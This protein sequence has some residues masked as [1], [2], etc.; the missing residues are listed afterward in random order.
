ML[1]FSVVSVCDFVCLSVRMFVNTV[2]WCQV[3]QGDANEKWQAFCSVIKGLEDTYVP[4]K[5]HGKL[6]K[7]AP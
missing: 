2:D 7:K 5:K 6:C 1:L 4:M 3:L